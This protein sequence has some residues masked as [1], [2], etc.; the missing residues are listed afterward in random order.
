MIQ[1]IERAMM[2]V[3]VL[4]KH[5]KR[6]FSV[7]EIFSE[8]E[9]P[10]S[11]I[12]RL[13]YTLETFDLV[14]RNEDKKEFRLGYTWLQLGLKM[15]HD[16]D[17]REKAHPLLEVLAHNVRETIY[18]NIS[19]QFTSIII[20]RV[21]SPKNVRII[22][23]I[24]EKI[25]YPIGAANKVLLAFSK[26]D[27]QIQFLGTVD[28]QDRKKLIE[29]LEQ[30]NEKGY[31]I[32]LGEKTKGTVSVAAPVFDLNG[33]PIAAISAECFEYDTDAEKLESIAKQVTKTAHQL[34]YE[35][36]YT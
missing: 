5:P 29:Q 15:Y 4:A 23:M 16:T 2:I 17:I 34:S 9:L 14:E 7:Q 3:N 25:P 8:T 10:T 13:L 36:G 28:E 31:S 11:T 19:K 26:R 12:Y 30:I 1:S 21:D 24:G 18:L 33:E 35:L 20:D 6:F 32:S 22:D 27:V